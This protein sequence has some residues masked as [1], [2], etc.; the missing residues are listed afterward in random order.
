MKLHDLI[1]RLQLLAE[2]EQQ[3]EVDVHLLNMNQ[4][5]IPWVCTP[6]TITVNVDDNTHRLQ[7]EFRESIRS[8]I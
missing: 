3:R 2:K 6:D 7:I 4:D 8:T 5:A 1:A